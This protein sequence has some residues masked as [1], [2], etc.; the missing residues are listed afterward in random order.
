MWRFPMSLTTYEHETTFQT[1][2]DFP[3]QAFLTGSLYSP[4]SIHSGSAGYF[5]FYLK[6]G[7]AEISFDQTV[8][9]L[10]PASYTVIPARAQILLT[11][12]AAPSEAACFYVSGSAADRAYQ[13]FSRDGNLVCMT[14][15]ESRIFDI[16][17]RILF[18]HPG[19]SNYNESIYLDLAEHLFTEIAA[20]AQT[21]QRT[22]HLPPL[23]AASMKQIF[24]T[25]YFEMLTL[26]VLAS[27]LHMN[28]FKLAKE[29]K[30][31]YGIAPIEYLIEKRIEVAKTLL[32]S[33]QKTVTQ[34]G[35][36]VSMENTP[37][38]ISLF[39]KRVGQTPLLYRRKMQRNCMPG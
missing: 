8:F 10:R 33:S 19:L 12:K 7:Y 29:F 39:K 32:A 27:E 26:D 14:G 18:F 15:A 11:P 24:D 20:V 16:L 4:L 17:L 38:F 28:K 1:N 25:R 2:Q 3:V 37:Y 35:M 9:S 34:V 31:Y 13:A 6:S 5:L 23:Y 36:D 30:N 22:N 21:D